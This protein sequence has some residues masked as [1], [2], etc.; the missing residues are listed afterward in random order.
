LFQS[1]GG[2]AFVAGS[3]ATPTMNASRTS[4]ERLSGSGNP[5]QRALREQFNPDPVAAVRRGA[6]VD[7]AST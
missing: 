3:T 5:A 2:A 7:G 1:V 6:C 4:A